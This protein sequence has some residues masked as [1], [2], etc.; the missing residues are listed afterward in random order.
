MVGGAGPMGGV[1]WVGV[2]GVRVYGVD[3]VELECVKVG[4]PG[5]EVDGVG[6][7]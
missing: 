1:M 5:V 7:C 2:H 6:L 4:E 3:T